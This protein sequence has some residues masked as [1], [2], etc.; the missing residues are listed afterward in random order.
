MQLVSL[1]P[2]VTLEAITAEMGWQVRVAE[3]LIETQAP[4]TDELA[5]MR[6]LSAGNTSQRAGEA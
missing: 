1:Y 3:T 6:R 4:T 2:G 5:I